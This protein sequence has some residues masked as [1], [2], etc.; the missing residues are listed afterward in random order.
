MINKDMRHMREYQGYF[1]VQQSAAPWSNGSF[2]T[3]KKNPL[4]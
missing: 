2:N 4:N 1:I 3:I